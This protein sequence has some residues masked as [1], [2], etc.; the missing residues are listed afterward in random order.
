MPSPSKTG[1]PIVNTGPTRGAVRSK[2]K[3][4]MWRKKRSD[5]GKPRK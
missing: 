2:T 5:A 3:R 1:G 4:G